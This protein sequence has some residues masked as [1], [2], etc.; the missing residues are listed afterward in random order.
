MIISVTDAAVGKELEDQF[1][2][3]SY[4]GGWGRD[5]PVRADA[6]SLDPRVSLGC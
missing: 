4:L 2:G 1:N 3:S 6:P 5:T